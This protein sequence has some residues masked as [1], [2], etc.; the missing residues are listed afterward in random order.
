MIKLNCIILLTVLCCAT[1]RKP[2]YTEKEKTARWLTHSLTYGVLSTTSSSTLP[3]GTAFGN[4]Q[5]FSD[6][7]INEG[8]GRLYFYTSHLDT[9]MQD[10]DVN[11]NVSFT[12]SEEMLGNRCTESFL[13]GHDAEDPRCVRLVFTGIWRR[14]LSQEEIGFANRS[15]F[16]RH[17]EMVDWPADFHFG[18][19]DVTHIWMIDIFG[20]AS[21]LEPAKFFEEKTVTSV[22]LPTDVRPPQ[23][24]PD[25]DDKALTA[26]WLAHTASFGVLSTTSQHLPGHDVAF[27]NPQSFC[28]GPKGDGRLYF[29]VSDMDAS[30]QDV[31]SNS[32]CS[33]A[34]SEE[35]VQSACSSGSIDVEDPRCVRLV[36]SGNMVDVTDAQEEAEAKNAIFERHPSMKSWP[37]DHHW[38]ITTLNLTTIWLIDTYGGA[39]IVDVDDY[40]RASFASAA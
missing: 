9:S 12:L 17:E 30:M 11:P 3:N 34:L 6:G 7:P 19:I 18:T 29:Y 26:R 36:L 2:I 22:D 14:E 25:T 33:F 21:V 16:S 27:G 35:F 8:K 4:V 15:L 32:E 28:D 39:S 20:G 13:D 40:Y 24:A 38:K 10:I 23:G 5:S 1:G 31:A 37:S